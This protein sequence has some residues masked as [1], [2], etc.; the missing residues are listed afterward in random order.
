MSRQ[1]PI[2]SKARADG[3]YEHGLHVLGPDLAYQRLAIVNVL[4]YGALDAGD[5]GWVLIDAGIP[6][7]ADLIF[8]ASQRS[9][10]S[11]RPPTW[12]K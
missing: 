2:D 1:I 7:T 10:S 11:A 12:S 5:R 9:A 3:E 6:G 8:S 4:F